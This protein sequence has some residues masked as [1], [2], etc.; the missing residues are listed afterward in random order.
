M[1]IKEFK[2]IGRLLKTLY[3]EV[4]KEALNNGIDIMSTEYDEIIARAREKILSNNGFTL[5]QYREAKAKVTLASDEEQNMLGLIEDSEKNI[6]LRMRKIE[7]VIEETHVPTVEEITD[8]AEEIAHKYVVPP[9]VT[10]Q[11]V[12]E[13]IEKDIYDPSPLIKKIDSLSEILFNI[14][15]PDLPTVPDFDKFKLGLR[16]E[17]EQNLKNSISIKWQAEMP[18]FRKL[19]MGL[20]GQ[21]DDIHREIDNSGANVTL[22]DVSA[23]STDATKSIYTMSSGIPVN[24][25][26]SDGNSLLYL[27]S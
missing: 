20:Q 9:Q 14:K 16:E 17:F 24:F 11:I 7:Q 4:E 10:N 18:D 3:A 12:K 27:N 22:A 15:I 8:I 5:E 1:T 6:S 25:K 19:A 21:I 2:K 13:T 23:N 26:S